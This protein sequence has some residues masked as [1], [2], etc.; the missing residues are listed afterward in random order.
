[1]KRFYAYKCF[2]LLKYRQKHHVDSHYWVCV[3][4]RLRIWI[5]MCFCLSV[6]MHCS[7]QHSSF[8]TTL[9]NSLFQSFINYLT[10]R[11]M[12]SA[13]YHSAVE[14]WIQTLLINWN[15]CTS[16][17]HRF[18]LSERMIVYSC[19]SVSEEPT[20]FMDLPWCLMHL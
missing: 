15:S 11:F 12:N 19:Y 17:N 3:W 2:I 9:I 1:M 8:I 10:L 6:R 4:M 14:L 20:C 16:A 18:I 5:S 13:L 7:K